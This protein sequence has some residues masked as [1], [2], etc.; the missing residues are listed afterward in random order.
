MKYGILGDIHGNLEA[1]EAVLEEMDR[2]GVEKY[3][4]VGDLVGYGAN[5]CEVISRVR[6]IGATVVAGNH[7]FAAVEK[8][9][10]DFFNTA[11]GAVLIVFPFVLGMSFLLLM[12]VFRSI[13][14]ERT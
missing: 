10:I 5:P 4:S 1:L 8:L 9:N 11:N 13:L 14:F 12:L 2:S 3:I 7:D 6:E